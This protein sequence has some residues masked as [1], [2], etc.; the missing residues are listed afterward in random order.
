MPSNKANPRRIKLL[1]VDDHPIV[2]EGIKLHLAAQ[3]EFIVVGEATSGVEAIPAAANLQPDVILMDISMPHQ[4][5]IAAMSQLRRRA[6]RAKILVLSMHKNREYITQMVRLGARGYLLKDIAPSELTRAI[7][8]VHAGEVC[9]SPSVSRVLLEEVVSSDSEAGGPSPSPPQLTCREREVL[10]QI[11][12]GYS[13][14]NIAHQ[15]GVSVRTI[16][17]HRERIMRKLEIHSVAG[18]T[19]YAIAQGMVEL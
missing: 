7:K 3:P 12:E 15:L 16:E 13:N 11:A 5:G 18:L 17:T 1:L 8:E 4:N 9:F 19:K 2:L 14:K 10:V 6:P